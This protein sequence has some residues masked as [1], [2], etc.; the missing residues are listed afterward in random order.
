MK[1]FK[2]ALNVKNCLIYLFWEIAITLDLDT[3][4]QIYTFPAFRLIR[5][6]I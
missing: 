4:L 6:Q 5:P 2:N 1:T 3:N